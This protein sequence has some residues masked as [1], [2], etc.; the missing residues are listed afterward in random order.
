MD[1]NSLAI[2]VAVVEAGS[3]TGAATRLGMPKSKVSRRLAQFEEQQKVR[4]LNRTTRSIRLTEPGNALYVQ[5][6]PLLGELEQLGDSIAKSQTVAQ[7]RLSIQTP[8]DFFAN[9]FAD[10][11]LGFLEEYPRVEL[12]IEQFSGHIPQNIDDSDI[13]FVLHQGA[14]PDSYHNAKSLMSLQQ[15]LYGS[16]RRYARDEL[17]REELSDQECLLEP[18]ERAWLFANRGELNAVRVK[19]RMA[20]SSQNMLIEACVAGLGIA[21]LLDADV[22]T[23]R[24]TGSLIKLLTPNPVEALSLTLLFRSQY[25]PLRARLFIDFFQ[26]NIG[27]LSSRLR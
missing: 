9:Q 6:Q 23:Q 10:L 13:S 22:E 19:G 20:V 2:F 27:R 25:L 21:K 26:S 8:S 12:T 15:S 14:L 1:L 11:C 17:L 4:L 3:L 24:R 7:G 16:P 18:G 5:A